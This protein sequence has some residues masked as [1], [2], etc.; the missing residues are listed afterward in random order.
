ME[1]TDGSSA[2]APFDPVHLS[3]SAYTDIARAILSLGCDVDAGS[4]RRERL[5]SIVPGS[6]AWKPR[7]A[8]VRPAPWVSGRGSSDRG[9][10]GNFNRRSW[11]AGRGY[12]P[13]GYVRGRGDGLAKFSWPKTGRG[14]RGGNRRGGQY[15]NPY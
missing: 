7:G 13:G 8:T 10:G 12:G 2:W 14:F 5:A 1:T 4:G 9:R 15:F 3:E 6:A 11:R